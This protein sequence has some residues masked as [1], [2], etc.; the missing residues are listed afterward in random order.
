MPANF[1]SLTRHIFIIED[2]EKEKNPE[3]DGLEKKKIQEA[4]YWNRKKI[5]VSE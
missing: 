4:E 1:V 3:T 2:D 5:L